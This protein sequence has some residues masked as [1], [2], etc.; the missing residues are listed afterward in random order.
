MNKP[1]LV[2]FL[3]IIVAAVLVVGAIVVF[4]KLPRKGSQESLGFPKNGAQVEPEE[5]LV[6]LGSSF[7]RAS[8][9]STNMQGENNDY[10]FSTGTK[11]SSI[12]LFLKSKAK[13]LTATNLAHPGANMQDILE[14]QLPEALGLNPKYV[15]LD[16]AG[17][18]VSKNSISEYKE[19]LTQIIDKINPQT[20][21]MI[22]TYPNFIKMRTA[23]FASCGE[24]K[25]GVKL[26]NLSE[27]NI[28]AFNQAMK[29][30]V[31]G[32]TNI[33]LVDAYNLFG[34]EDIGDYDCLHVNL[35]A[36]EKIA[37]EFIKALQ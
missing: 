28:L 29:D 31:K 12:Y 35:G 11:I 26:E 18:L 8:N 36:Q 37:K 6:A 24:N 34:P 21:I 3:A 1:S 14:R 25:V 9:L 19:N 4:G 22:F 15:T 17:D 16:P 5:R 32:K 13:S 7:S 20:T 10:S 23:S 27:K 30:A 2:Q 33:V